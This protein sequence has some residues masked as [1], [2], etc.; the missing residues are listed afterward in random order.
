M[1]LNSLFLL[2]ESIKI[3]ATEVGL[4][5][6]TPTVGN[7]LRNA[8]G[9]ITVLVGIAS[10]I[11]IVVGGLQ[12]IGSAGDPQRYKHGRETVTYAVVGLI[13]TILAYA[14]VTFIASN[15]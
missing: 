1:I 7:A 15:L 4:P 9:L 2:A 5:V 8:L 6:S 11:A 13:V 14:V 3:K 10:V 12:I